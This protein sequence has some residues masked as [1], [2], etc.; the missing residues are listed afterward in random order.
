MTDSSISLSL[1]SGRGLRQLD[2]D[3]L[4]RALAGVDGVQLFLSFQL[5]GQRAVD[6]REEAHVVR[7]SPGR[8][9]EERRRRCGR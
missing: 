8:R 3:V 7:Q 4:Q 9:L 1:L 5:D 6:V 2:E